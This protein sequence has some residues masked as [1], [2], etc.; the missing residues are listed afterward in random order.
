MT[1]ALALGVGSYLLRAIGLTMFT[2]REMPAWA[3]RPL[4]Y[5]PP[6]VLAVLV[7]TRILDAGA[8]GFDP[9]LIG[10]AVGIGLVVLR[11]PLAVAMVAAAAV[12]AGLR[13]FL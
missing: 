12:T 13:L 3:E 2:S 9:S 10:I 4:Q 5:V 11:A 6:A 1:T 7:V 8:A